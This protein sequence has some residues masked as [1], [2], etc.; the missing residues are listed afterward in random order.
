MRVERNE[1]TDGRTVIKCWKSRDDGEAS[2]PTIVSVWEIHIPTDY[3]IVNGQHIIEFLSAVREDDLTPLVLSKEE[4][5]D[6][7]TAVTRTVADYDP[8][9]KV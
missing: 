2:D 3:D 6:I 1:T 5:D 8:D 9:W 4:K 7:I